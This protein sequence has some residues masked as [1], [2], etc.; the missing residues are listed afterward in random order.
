VAKGAQLAEVRTKVSSKAIS[1]DVGVGNVGLF[2]RPS[3]LHLLIKCNPSWFKSMR[4]PCWVRAEL[5][6]Y[7]ALHSQLFMAIILHMNGIWTKRTPLF[8]ITISIN[9]YEQYKYF[10]PLTVSEII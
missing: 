8:S 5:R 7:E 1:R 2:Y 10:S 4:H 3:Y 6:W 9:Y